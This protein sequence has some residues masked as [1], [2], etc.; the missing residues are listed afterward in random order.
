MSTVD[1]E[2]AVAA[3]Q[4]TVTLTVAGRPPATATI[5]G[6]LDPAHFDGA[7]DRRIPAETRGKLGR[8]LFDAVI[9]EDTA[10]L[11]NEVDEDGTPLRLR[12]RIPPPLR[13]L[14]WELLASGAD[15]LALRR[16]GT[17]WRGGPPRAGAEVDGP[18]RVLVVV[19]N[20]TD[21]QVLGDE[22]LAGL[23][24]AAAECPAR[25]HIEI[26]DG[27]DRDRL[28]KEIDRLRPHVLHFI[29]HGMPRVPGRAAALAFNWVTAGRPQGAGWE[30]ASTEVGLMM[31]DDWTPRLVV[32]NACR[33]A[34]DALDQVGGVAEAFLRAG[35]GAV[36]AMQADVESPA[37]ATFAGLL[38]QGIFAG[39]GL[40]RAVAA[41]R[42]E[43]A[44][45]TG[46]TGEWAIPVLT[47]RTDPADVVRTG[48]RRPAE[49]IAGL[50][51]RPEYQMLRNFLDHAP[52]RRDAWWALDPLTATPPRSLL[53]VG[54]RS[55]NPHKP[56]GKT[57]FTRF[58]LLTYFLRGYRVTYVDLGVPLARPDGEHA[59]TKTWLHVLQMM[60]EA[61][62]D[63]GQAEP[64]PAAAFAGFDALF[65][66]LAGE[67]AGWSGERW[68][69]DE[70][71]P[72]A[73]EQRDR[74]LDGF[75][76]ALAAA[77]GDRPHVIALDNA[78]Q[79]LPESFDSAIYPSL[80]RPV[81]AAGG[82]LRLML[83]GKADWL[84]ARLPGRD[85]AYW[86]P[87]VTIGDFEAPQM[88]RLA[89]DYCRRRGLPFELLKPV[90]G[91]ICG[92]S[93]QAWVTRFDEVLD[94]IG[95]VAP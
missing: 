83:V 11:W 71:R 9:R 85:Q 64:L 54:G 84:A 5:T 15:R 44:R 1:A 24:G 52:G 76:T 51:A 69:F 93:P 61:C 94:V 37:A 19:C 43:L 49:Q 45:T 88:M 62:T 4:R 2:L 60:R 50:T 75:R 21:R 32:V 22:E 81:A 55:G 89:R 77:A 34:A 35:A 57:W 73:A 72:R 95:P 38:Y 6:V 46:D 68:R 79:V 90:F 25:A 18:L 30:L 80:L 28:A 56:T 78:E 29:G 91:A 41:A 8:E 92:V 16:G 31:S 63:P 70:N 67:P 42:T 39:L 17:L 40:D 27:P 23:T 66:T 65:G 87:V 20:P 74:I 12:L 59:L 10:R 3:D 14:P 36:V 13:G 26:V 58:S 48:F 82:G 33:T 53:V 47:C 86:G 7:L